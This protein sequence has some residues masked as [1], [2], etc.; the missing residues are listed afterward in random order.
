LFL[1][2]RKTQKIGVESKHSPISRKSCS[3]SRLCTANS[4]KLIG[5]V[6]EFMRFVDNSQLKSVVAVCFGSLFFYSLELV[7]HF[8]VGAYV[9]YVVDE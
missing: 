8:C 5:F 4:R 9:R 1:F 7:W 2:S 6:L 3:V